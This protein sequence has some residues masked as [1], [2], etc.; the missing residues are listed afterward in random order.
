MNVRPTGGARTEELPE[1][2]INSADDPVRAAPAMHAGFLEGATATGEA[3][4]H[5]LSVRIG[6]WLDEDGSVRQARWRAVRDAGLRACA[7]AGCALL[8]AGVDP[9]QVGADGLRRGAVSSHARDCAEVV[10]AAIEAALLVSA[11]R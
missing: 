7:E 3:T 9:A 11:D 6:L 2:L 10:A 1:A 4:R 8:E 5:Q